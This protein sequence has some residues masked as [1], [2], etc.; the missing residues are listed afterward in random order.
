MQKL[1]NTYSYTQADWMSTLNLAQATDL[2]ALI[3]NLGPDP[4]DWQ[5]ARARA[6]Y[7]ICAT[8]TP[9]LKLAL[10]LDMSVLPSDTEHDML[11]LVDLVEELSNLL[12]S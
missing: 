1:G 5:F 9:A 6:A 2:D 3:L 7:N 12:P 11:R 8:S 4:E 10:S